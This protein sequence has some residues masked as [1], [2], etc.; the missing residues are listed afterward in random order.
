MRRGERRIGS[1]LAP[2]K[3]LHDEELTI[4]LDSLE[5]LIAKPHSPDNVVPVREVAGTPVRQVAV[6]SS[7]N[8]SFRDLMMVAKILKGKQ[9]APNLHM[10]L[11][12]GSRQIL[13]NLLKTGAAMDLTRAGVRSLEVACGPCIGMGAAPPSHGN[14]VRTFNRNFP[15]RSGTEQDAVWLCS[16]EVAAATALYGHYGSPNVRRGATR[17]GA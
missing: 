7:V 10:T 14:S 17:R 1:R 8:S 15:G 16:P 13:V 11:S 9:I 5:P 2:M 3:P 12:P 6:G 4:D